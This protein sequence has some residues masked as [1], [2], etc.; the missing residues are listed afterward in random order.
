M[1]SQYMWKCNL[2]SLMESKGITQRELSAQTGVASTTISRM[3]NNHLNRIDI[4]ILTTFAK[5]FDIQD[6]AE[7]FELVIEK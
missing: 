6:G 7:L 4:G 2:R 5:F 3:C 1:P